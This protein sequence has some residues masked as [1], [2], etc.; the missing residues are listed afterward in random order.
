M[1]IA[2]TI[3]WCRCFSHR[4]LKRLNS[5][6][7][8]IPL[9]AYSYETHTKNIQQYD[10]TTFSPHCIYICIVYSICIMISDSFLDMT[11]T[12]TKLNWI[13]I[14]NYFFFPLSNLRMHGL[15]YCLF[16]SKAS[17]TITQY[18]HQLQIIISQWWMVTSLKSIWVIV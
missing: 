17:Y 9:K 5:K 2:V 4:S 14:F 7:F 10:K 1:I 3:H 13:I 15:V 6:G 18:A 11:W 16:C 8:I 12:A